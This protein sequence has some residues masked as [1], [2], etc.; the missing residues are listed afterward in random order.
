MSFTTRP[1]IVSTR[2]VVSTTHWL[3][4]ASALT[5]LRNGGNAFDAAVSAGFVLQIVEPHMNGPGGEVS[6]VLYS[7]AENRVLVI[8]GQGSA[9]AAATI[10]AF[11]N[12]GITLIPGSGVLPAVVPGA[13][14]AWMLLLRDHGRLPLRDVLSPALQ[15]ARVGIPISQPIHQ[16]IDAAHRLFVSEWPTSGAVYLAGGNT[17]TVGARF[18]NLALAETYERILK[19]AESKGPDR[20]A[21]IDEARRCWYEGFVAEAI[22]TFYRT[23]TLADAT[24]AHHR[25]L[26]TGDDMTHWRASQEEAVTFDYHGFEVCKCGPWTQ[27]PVFLQQL[28]LL[29]HFDL[30]AMDWNGAEVVHTILECA[31][32]AFA[33]RETFYGDP[34][35]VDVPLETLLSEEYN[36]QRAQLVTDQCLSRIPAGVDRRIW[37]R[38]RLRRSGQA[39]TRARF[40]VR[41]SSRSRA[42][43]HRR[44]RVP[45]M[46]ARRRKRR[47]M[48][49][50]HRR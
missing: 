30:G 24:G 16:V 33:D 31:K 35:F 21:E 46:P 27:G 44:V 39:G 3:A 36:R 23:E 28:A 26:L 17:P 10:D 9:P 50:G 19:E 45:G 32:L 15:Y 42:D 25:G 38:T 43:Q 1:E 11:V 5:I 34:K 41:P 48:P 40:A 20:I 8:A 12:L 13:F 4:S 37:G 47:H 49:C 22:D 29:K 14:D 7:A 18:R 2:A 6:I